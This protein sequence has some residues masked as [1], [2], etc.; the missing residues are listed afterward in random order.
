MKKLLAALIA[1]LFITIST[2]GQLSGNLSGEGT[3]KY[4]LVQK[5]NSAGISSNS[6]PLIA[7]CTITENQSCGIYLAFTMDV[8]IDNCDITYNHSN[9]HGG[10]ICMFGANAIITNCLIDHNTC[11]DS[12]AGIWTDYGATLENCIITYN[13]ANTACGV[14]NHWDGYDSNYLNSL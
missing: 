6:N 12:R 2:Q 10:G 11:D 13:Y 7:H 5:S 14:C 8:Q 9:W 3:M 1:A 4:C